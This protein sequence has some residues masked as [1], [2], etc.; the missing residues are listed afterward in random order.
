MKYNACPLVTFNVFMMEITKLSSLFVSL[1]IIISIL[2]CILIYKA[3][4]SKEDVK[5]RND[6]E[7]IDENVD[8]FEKPSMSLRLKSAYVQI[9]C[10]GYTSITV[11]LLNNINS[12]TI[13]DKCLMFLDASIKCSDR[14]AIF[15]V[16]ILLILFW[17]SPFII[18]LFFGCRWLS[19]C[20]ITLNQFLIILTIPP[21]VLIFYI[22]IR[23][24]DIQRRLNHH[25]A[26]TSKYILQIIGPYRMKKNAF[27]GEPQTG[28]V[29]DCIYLLRCF[30]MSL[31][32]VL[33]NESFDRLVMVCVIMLLFLVLHLHVKPFKM[34]RMNQMEVLSSVSIL[35]MAFLC[36]IMNSHVKSTIIENVMYMFVVCSFTPI[37]AYVAFIFYDVILEFVFDFIGNL[38][39]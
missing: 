20:K 32:C 29:W 5:S 9:I 25:Q 7:V 16:C 35:L 31:A 10:F 22:K 11:L 18:G 28:I 27:R 8:E 13:E 23:K 19:C 4:K 39:G 6:Y 3:G 26:S 21:T 17:C 2:V 24:P 1:A 34:V 33:L 36:F 15:I 37:I 30:V 14:E 12:I 38:I